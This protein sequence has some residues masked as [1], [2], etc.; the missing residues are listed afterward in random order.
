M[1]KINLKIPAASFEL[2][3]NRIT[4]ILIDEFNN[5]KSNADYNQLLNI[6]TFTCS[7]VKAFDVSELPALNVSLHKGGY[8]NKH[9]GN[10]DGSYTFHIDIYTAVNDTEERPGDEQSQE[11]LEKLLGAARY[12]LED[13]VYNTLGFAAPF[14]KRV[15]ASDILIAEADKDD[16]RNVAMGRLLFNVMVPESSILPEPKLIEGYD[17]H[18]KIGNTNKGYYYSGE[19]Y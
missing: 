14:I 4:D 8:G 1:S 18:V 3:R 15:W 10:V 19:N 13:P 9:Q 11:D 17:T 6:K 7:R 5:Q 12:I 2:V 16:A